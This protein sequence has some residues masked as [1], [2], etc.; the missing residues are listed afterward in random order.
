MDLRRVV[1]IWRA[2]WILTSVLL[3]L[4]MVGAVE[5]AAKLPRYYQSASSVVLLASRV[6]STQNG[7]NPF[8]S[9]SPSLTLTADAVSRTLMAPGTVR[10]LAAQGFTASYTV[11]LPP[12]TTATTGSVLLVTVTGT[13]AAGV[14]RTLQAVTAQ[15]GPQLAQLQ[16]G[17]P[18]RGQVRAVT[19]SFPPQATLS[20][21]Q[22]ARPLVVIGALLLVI[23]LGTPIVVDGMA[24]RRQL[25]GRSALPDHS[26]LSPDRALRDIPSFPHRS[27]LREEPTIPVELA[28]PG[29]ATGSA[30]QQDGHDPA[31]GEPRLPSSSW[32]PARNGGPSRH[33]S[34]ATGRRAGPG[35]VSRS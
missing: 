3:I 32:P 14:Q 13:D 19:L 1:R 21:S 11:A 34:G 17:V 4:A 18:A 33:A 20:I 16:L 29:G 30:H 12:Y 24:T 27:A 26:A 31:Q 28:F 25:R 23:C 9:F 22:T 8:L 2:R 6:A 10:Q 15:I 7:G 35:D 5:A